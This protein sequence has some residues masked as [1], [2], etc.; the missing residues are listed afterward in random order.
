MRGHIHKRGKN[1]WAVVVDIGR[2]EDGKRRQ[3]WQTF[4]TEGEAEAALTEVLGKLAVDEYVA[5]S[6]ATVGEYLRKTW[7][8]HLDDQVEAGKLRPSTVSQY[9]TLTEAHIIPRLGTVKLRSLNAV[10]LDNLYAELRRNGRRAPRRNQSPGLSESSIRA[11]HITVSKALSHAV[12][13]GVLAKN[14]AK[15]A[16]TPAAHAAEQTPWTAEELA[17]F[18]ETTQSD[19]LYPAWLLA[20]TT[21]LRRGELAGL[22]WSDLN[23]DEGTL[24]VS[25]ARVVVGYK[26]VD[27]TPKTP[28]SRRTIALAPAVVETLKGHRT[29]QKAE[30]LK[31]GRTWAEDGLLLVREDGQ[32]YHPQYLTQS[33]QRAAKRAGVPVLPLHSTRHN[34]ATNG[35][36][37]G[38]D[39]L[40]MSRRLGHSSVAITGDIY[41][42][43]V[44]ELDQ[45]AANR[46]ADLVLLPG[47]PTADLG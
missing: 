12:K 18:V 37:A 19:R 35:L 29:R 30:C 17:K 47:K 33:F 1:S 16:E 20:L 10:H 36:R 34:H 45:E 39:L 8:P 15:N 5:P 32:P 44:E 3:R 6:K 21:G 25:V 27:S 9:R 40:T 41:S 14:V 23:L 42:H 46:T 43:L 4:K 2:D 11:V 31:W 22:R 7:L 13:K 28:K 24:T 38:V 26:V